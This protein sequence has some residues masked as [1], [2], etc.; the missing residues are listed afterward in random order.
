MR[1]VDRCIAEEVVTA[2]QAECWGAKSC[3]GNINSER[4]AAAFDVWGP[5][6]PSPLTARAFGVA[7][8][9][10]RSPVRVVDSR[11]ALTVSDRLFSLTPG[12]FDRDLFSG[13]VS[14]V[15]GHKPCRGVVSNLPSS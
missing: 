3:A 15:V 8:C 13:P 11:L 2:F 5:N 7:F 1:R 14:C 10:V 6:L 9:G 12:T 4:S